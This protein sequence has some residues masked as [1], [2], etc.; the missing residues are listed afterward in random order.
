MSWLGACA[1]VSL[2]GVEAKEVS[3]VFVIG[4]IMLMI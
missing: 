2:I 4:V 3:I 1:S